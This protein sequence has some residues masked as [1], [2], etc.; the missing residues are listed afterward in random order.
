MARPGSAADRLINQAPLRQGGP[1]QLIG[2]AL[3]A[4]L[5]PPLALGDAPLV[6]GHRQLGAGLG[7]EGWDG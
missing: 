7:G 2:I 4:S 1:V 6:K 5:G 3:S